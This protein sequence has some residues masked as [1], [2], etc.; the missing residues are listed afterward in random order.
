M[1]SDTQDAKFNE[2]LASMGWENLS[3]F[4]IVD[5]IYKKGWFI[6]IK[7]HNGQF[8]ADV[9]PTKR[10]TYT[11]ISKLYPTYEKALKKG[12]KLGIQAILDY[13]KNI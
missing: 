11:R 9:S 1:D 7:D 2:R 5:L 4:E 8:M 10:T 12:I 3:L 6:Q 13:E